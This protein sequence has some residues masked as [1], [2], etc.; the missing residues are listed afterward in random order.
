MLDDSGKEVAEFHTMGCNPYFH[1]PICTALPSRSRL[2]V[3][4]KLEYTHA[5]VL[6]NVCAA[7]GSLKVSRP[8]AARLMVRSDVRGKPRSIVAHASKLRRSPAG[9]PVFCV[10]NSRPRRQVLLHHQ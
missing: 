1:L 6:E 9:R 5:L 4:V 2:A 7:A 3:F 8:S 10:A